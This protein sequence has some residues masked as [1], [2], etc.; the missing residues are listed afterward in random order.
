MAA[1]VRPSAMRFSSKTQSATIVSP[2][3]EGVDSVWNENAVG[4]GHACLAVEERRV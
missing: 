3:E 2:R 1:E 4:D